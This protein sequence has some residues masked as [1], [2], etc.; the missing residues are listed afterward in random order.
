MKTIKRI[1]KKTELIRYK[2]TKRIIKYL[3][4]S[5]YKK[6]FLL[7]LINQTP[8][9]LFNQVSLIPRPTTII[10][11]K[12][13]KNK[14]IEGA[15]IGVHKGLNSKNILKEL[16]IRKI[17]LIDPWINYI[18]K[19]FKFSKQEENYN[20]VLEQFKND[21]RIKIIKE[22]SH[23][24]IKY[25]TDN[26]LDFVYIDGNHF[27]KH[28]YEDI[29]LWFKKVKYGGIIAG[30]DIFNTT[31]VLDAVKDFCCKNKIK[32]YI[33]LPDWYFIK[34]KNEVY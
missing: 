16:N 5:L 30:H 32:F 21:K 15:E 4:P 24:A 26:S 18:E 22:T 23:N 17:Y 31:D 10:M 8:L 33:E 11:K 27:Y 19:N 3:T 13:F 2:I 29:T 28:V 9:N 1:I 34:I 12:I 7:S 20:L 14:L 25:I 6:L